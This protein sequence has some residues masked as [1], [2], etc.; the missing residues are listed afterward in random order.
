MRALPRPLD[1]PGI[2]LG[3]RVR[4][5]HELVVGERASPRRARG[6]G[7]WMSW[8]SHWRDRAKQRGSGTTGPTQAVACH[9]SCGR[10]RAIVRIEPVAEPNEPHRRE[11][12]DAPGIE[13]ERSRCSPEKI[14][15]TPRNAQHALRLRPNLGA[16]DPMATDM[17]VPR[18][19]V[20]VR[21]MAVMPK[22]RRDEPRMRCSGRRC[23]GQAL[24]AKKNAASCS[25]GHEASCRLLEAAARTTRATA[26]VIRTRVRM[27][28]AHRRS[29]RRRRP[30]TG[31]GGRARR[32]RCRGRR[33]CARPRA[34]R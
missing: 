20:V 32:R 10:G 27:P 3:A 2:G 34:A 23:S 13:C 17:V 16:N 26:A 24:D 14:S 9:R 8:V 5:G 15:L 30:S 19:F 18:C 12:V 7:A 29:R 6:R 25:L 31:A 33:S 1:H 11:T 21:F 22:A 28:R 4:I